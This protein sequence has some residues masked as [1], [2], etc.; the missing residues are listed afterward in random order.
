MSNAI[1]GPG[2]LLQVDVSGTYTTIAEV[3]DISGPETSVDVVEVT[4][5]DSPDNFE[6]I[7]PTLKRGGTTSF[8]VNFVPTD[9]THDSTTGLLSYLNARSLQDWQIVLPGTGLSVQ[10]SGYVVKW[11]PK[12]PVANVASA[13]MD[14]R[15]SGPVTIAASL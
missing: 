1:A 12:F 3:K 6:E 2:F 15:V 7:I 10:F 11:G 4:N 13:S 9:A 5:Q 8:D 14:I